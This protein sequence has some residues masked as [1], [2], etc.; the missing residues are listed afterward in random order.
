[1]H[2]II[3]VLFS[4]F[5]REK[6]DMKTLFKIQEEA[7]LKF[8]IHE[9]NKSHPDEEI[10]AL[11]QASC[12]ILKVELTDLLESFGYYIAPELLK[13]Y[14]SYLNPEWKSLDLLG[15]I[16]E[17]MHRVVRSN[18]PDA[19]PPKLEISRISK[20]QVRIIYTSPRK[21]ISLGVGIIKA[22]GDNYQEKLKIEQIDIEDGT[23]LDIF[24][25]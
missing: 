13:T 10:V 21:I 18:T 22:I 6:H 25:M 7:G 24:L 12:K 1:M 14:K 17:T 11:L 2:G 9:V 3:F 23:Q 15:H 5:V 8:K 4:K 19:D 20:D 16:E